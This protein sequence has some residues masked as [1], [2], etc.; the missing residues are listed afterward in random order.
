MI[1]PNR[2]NIYSIMIYCHHVKIRYSKFNETKVRSRDKLSFGNGK[3]GY[4]KTTDQN[5]RDFAA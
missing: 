2:P 1:L 3:C 5:F 4:R